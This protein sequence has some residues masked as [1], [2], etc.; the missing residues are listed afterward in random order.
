MVHLWW[1]T[2][3]MKKCYN[4]LKDGGWFLCFTDWRQLPLTC[5]A[6][7]AAGFRWE[8][9]NVWHKPNGRP[10][11]RGFARQDEFIVV[12]V[13][14]TPQ[15]GM[16]PEN[17]GHKTYAQMWQGMCSAKE[18]ELHITPKPVEMLKHWLQVCRP[19][20]LVLDPFAGSGSTLVA[21]QELGLRAI[22]IELTEHYYHIARARL[23]EQLPLT[24]ST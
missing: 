14:G 8:G 6:T 5:F 13:K 17:Y 18:R 7:E 1:T 12:G 16:K 20:A 2:A 23:A 15:S 3:W 22:G 24:I 21:A 9:V 10:N 11:L 4:A 19:G